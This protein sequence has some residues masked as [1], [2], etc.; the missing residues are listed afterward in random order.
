MSICRT[1]IIFSVLYIPICLLYYWWLLTLHSGLSSLLLV[2][3][4]SSFRPVFFITDGSSHFIPAY[5]IYYW[6]L[7]TF[8][9]GLPLCYW[10][11]L[12]FHSGLS[13]FFWW[14]FT[15]HS[16]LSSLLLVVSH[17][18]FRPVFCITGGS[19]LFILVCLLCYLFIIVRFCSSSL[20]IPAYLL[21]YCWLFTL[22]SGLSSVLITGGSSLCCIFLSVTT[23]VDPI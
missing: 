17:F 19:S 6:W 16:G 9:S 20:L 13:F 1:K 3:P 7:L 11:L 21:Y 5:L 14:L 18:L 15:L 22:H 23:Y 2:A 12:T 10:W 4:H 8:H